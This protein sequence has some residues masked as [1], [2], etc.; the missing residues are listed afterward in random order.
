MKKQLHIKKVLFVCTLLAVS[1][2]SI[3]QTGWLQIIHNS[4]DPAAAN[5]AIWVI[6]GNTATKKFDNFK[7][8][9]ATGYNEYTAIVPI[10]IAI[11]PAGAATVADTIAGLTSELNLTANA[12]YIAMAIGNL[13]TGYA[14]NPNGK[15]IDFR[16][17]VVENARIDP[18]NS[19]QFEFIVIN[20]ST[21]MPTINIIDE[22]NTKNW[23]SG[24][25]YG[26]ISSYTAMPGNM[27]RFFIQDSATKNTLVT[28]GGNFGWNQRT[29]VLFTSG[30]LN[31]SANN[32]GIKQEIYL[33]VDNLVLPMTELTTTSLNE[34]LKT[35]Q[36]NSYPNP[37]ITNL[38]IEFTLTDNSP[39]AL[40]VCDNLG[41]T[42]YTET[43][44]GIAGSNSLKVNTT[45]FKT[46]V[47]FYTLK[48]KEGINTTRFAVNK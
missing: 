21:D 5:V 33:N 32:N 34:R 45:S 3:A 12:N 19:A 40:K 25:S 28:Y 6:E 38:N 13:G 23:G 31:P 10:K 8:R 27:Y 14:A 18:N 48:T 1:F 35:L 47:Y 24:I 15:N 11:S 22:D 16:L 43:T 29:G 44:M 17:L 46:G 2:G 4:A 41:R 39:L 20:G 26:E 42:V 37:S 9:Q 36:V 30:Y 7:F